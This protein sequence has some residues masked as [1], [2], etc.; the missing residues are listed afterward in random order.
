MKDVSLRPLLPQRTYVRAFEDHIHVSPAGQKKL[1]AIP[2]Y[3]VKPS[4]HFRVQA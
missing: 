4:L 2:F 3:I 1:E